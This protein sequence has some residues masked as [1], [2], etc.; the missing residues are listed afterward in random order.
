V[1][2]AFFSEVGRGA[3]TLFVSISRVASFNKVPS[4]RLLSAGSATAA[5]CFSG[6]WEDECAAAFAGSEKARNAYP[7]RLKCCLSSSSISVLP[8]LTNFLGRGEAF[9]CSSTGGLGVGGGVG[10][11][12]GGGGGACWGVGSAFFF[13]PK[14]LK[15]RLLVL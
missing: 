11:F 14:R 9:R 5:L 15:L 3:S 10:S 4:L 6:V 12:A 2:S 7:S 13:L 1:L 8:F